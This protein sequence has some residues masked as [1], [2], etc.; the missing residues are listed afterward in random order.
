M[1]LNCRPQV[2][3]ATYQQAIDLGSAS[4]PAKLDALNQEVR[5]AVDMANGGGFPTCSSDPNQP[6]AEAAAPG[7]L[8]DSVRGEI[9]DAITRANQAW[10]D[11]TFN[12]NTS[13]LD[14]QVAGDL[15]KADQDEIQQLRNAGQRRTNT[16]TDFQ[17]L[18]VTLDAPGHAIV[19]TRE[20]WSAVTTAMATG[21]VVQQVAPTTYTETYVVAFQNGGWIVTRNDV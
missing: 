19:H 15:L 4:A 16:N 8:S 20:T 13:E 1:F 11:T 3:A 18:D 6:A 12:L 7:T 14:G 17:V 10:K 9:L 5:G 21:R 2:A